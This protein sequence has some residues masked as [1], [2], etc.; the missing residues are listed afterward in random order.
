MPFTRMAQ[1]MRQVLKPGGPIDVVGL[2]LKSTC[3]VRTAFID[4]A[5]TEV[6]RIP[7]Q[8]A[9]GEPIT[10]LQQLAIMVLKDSAR[11]E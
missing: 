10:A 6:E 1:E 9:H 5:I 11:I 2:H 4:A 3:F 7:T 8:L